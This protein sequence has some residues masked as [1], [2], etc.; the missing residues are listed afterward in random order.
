MTKLAEGDRKG[1]QEHFD[2]VIK[3]RAF[4]W[5]PYDMSWVFQARLAKDPT[6]PR[7]ISKGAVEGQSMK[8]IESNGAVVEL[9]R[10][11]KRLAGRTI[12]ESVDL[13]VAGGEFFALVGPSG[14]GKSTLLRL[15]SGIDVPD[16]GQVWLGGRDVTALPPF[17]RPVHTVFQNYALFPHLDVAEN[18]G[19]ALQMAGYPRAERKARVARALDWVEMGRFINRS[20]H[21]LSGG[22]RQRVALARALVDE[23]SSVLLDEPLSALDPHL[24]VQTLN[25]LQDIQARL[26]VT[27]LYVT[28]DREE[29]L[30]AAHR[31]GILNGGRLEQVGTPQE[32]YQR[33]VS[34]FVASF[35]GPIN[36]LHGELT[37]AEDRPGVRL[38]SG[39]FLPLDGRALPPPGPVRL[40]VRPEDIE[41]S[42]EGLLHARVI[43]RQFCGASIWLRLESQGIVDLLAE[44]RADA[45]PP[46]VGD[47]VCISWTPHA[48]HLFGADL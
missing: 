16:A 45:R 39:P 36:W 21:Q 31:I 5:D 14:S 18:V 25:L 9:R 43:A 12:L 30:R 26:N 27:Y 35:V 42:A 40:G 1:A 10:I 19:F 48:V 33:P 32:V 22:E 4:Q 8:A 24:R 17:R 2:K 29:A 46:A 38:S 47:L 37:T 41:L 15:V 11:T 34:A 7:W 23:P 6:W 28:H 3:T 44:V 13:T 20:I